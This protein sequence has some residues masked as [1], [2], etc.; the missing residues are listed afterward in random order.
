MHSWF[1]SSVAAAP[2]N[3]VGGSVCSKLPRGPAA[4]FEISLLFARW[5]VLLLLLLPQKCV[6]LSLS[7][8]LLPPQMPHIWFFLRPCPHLHL[9][10]CPH[11]DL[12]SLIP[13]LFSW[14]F[15]FQKKIWNSH[16]WKNRAL[17]DSL[18]LSGSLVSLFLI[19]YGD[20]VIFS[21]FRALSISTHLWL[22]PLHDPGLCLLPR[23]PFPNNCS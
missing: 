7:S 16:L 11:S 9:E 8:V 6:C 21:V 5:W 13:K 2:R 14:M 10:V 15:C 17:L 19:R 1:P 4:P 3:M 18:H 12:H 23:L 22:G 20:T